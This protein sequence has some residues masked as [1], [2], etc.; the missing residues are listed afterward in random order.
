MK[1]CAS[2]SATGKIISKCTLIQSKITDTPTCGATHCP[3]VRK[4]VGDPWGLWQVYQH[5]CPCH[6]T[7]THHLENVYLLGIQWT[8]FILFSG[9]GQHSLFLPPWPWRRFVSLRRKGWFVINVQESQLLPEGQSLAIGFSLRVFSGWKITK[10]TGGS[11]LMEP[12]PTW[13]TVCFPL[14]L[15]KLQGLITTPYWTWFVWI[16]ADD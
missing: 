5:H 2:C 13:G 7:C 15:V 14:R 10:D 11:C 9:R 1:M 12:V 8:D 6:S 16:Y 4:Q 3:F